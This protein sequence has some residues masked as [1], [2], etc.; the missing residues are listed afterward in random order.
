MLNDISTESPP[1]VPTCEK[2][3]F[4]CANNRCISSTLRCNFFNDC[5]D[6][7]SDEINCKTGDG[8]HV[9]NVSVLRIVTEL[10][11]VKCQDIYTDTVD[12]VCV[13]MCRD[14]TK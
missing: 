5:E 3:E 4:L 6:Y 1:A 8:V 2:D 9:E 14:Q 13:F 11:F 10:R 12:L 7:G